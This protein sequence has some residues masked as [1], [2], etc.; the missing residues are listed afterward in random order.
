MGGGGKAYS[1]TCS[2]SISHL[3]P[4]RYFIVQISSRHLSPGRPPIGCAFIMLAASL[5]IDLS[6][7]STHASV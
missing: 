7:Y 4:L 5:A 6:R 1:P 3:N 2:P